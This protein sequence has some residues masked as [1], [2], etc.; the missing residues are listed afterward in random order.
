M[1]KWLCF[2]FFWKRLE[3][4]PAGLVDCSTASHAEASPDSA[5]P[6]KYT[7]WTDISSKVNLVESERD[8]FDPCVHKPLDF[9]QPVAQIP[10][11]VFSLPIDSCT[12][13]QHTFI[14]GVQYY[15]KGRWLPS[16]TYQ[17]SRSLDAVKKYEFFVSRNCK[18]RC[19]GIQNVAHHAIRETRSY[20][21][22]DVC[23]NFR[24]I[25]EN[26]SSV[27]RSA[28]V[29]HMY[30]VPFPGHWQNLKA[31]PTGSI[32]GPWWHSS[33]DMTRAFEQSMNRCTI[34]C[35]YF[36]CGR[37]DQMSRSTAYWGIVKVVDMPPQLSI[38]Y[39]DKMWFYAR[40]A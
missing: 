36:V 2:F 9:F 40:A 20:K 37:L 6:C 3:V 7:R 23:G 11:Y 24:R 30:V 8:S 32:P 14:F 13:K 4:A 39:L 17:Q 34:G 16:P 5:T 12:R 33:R 18:S 25:A 1:M 15:S 22:W 29:L 35:F 31:F 26:D 21:H 27:F 38:S 10:S 28:L 19:R